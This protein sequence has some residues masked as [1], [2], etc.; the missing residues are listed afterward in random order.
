ML[1]LR[2]KRQVRKSKRIP[3]VPKFRNIKFLERQYSAMIMQYVSLFKKEFEDHVLSYLSQISLSAQSEGLT[4]RDSWDDTLEQLMTTFN[5]GLTKATNFNQLQNDL[6]I[7]ASNVNQNNSEQLSQVIRKMFNIDLLA[8]EPWLK[9]TMNSFV[10][11]GVSLITNISQKTQN[12]LTGL[13]QRDIKLGKRFETIKKEIM[14][15]NLKPGVFDKLSTRAELIARDQVGK[16]NGQ[17]SRMRQKDIGIEFYVWRTSGDERVRQSHAVLDGKYCSWN[18]D[19]VY[20]DT[21][22]DAIDGK[23]KKRNSIGAFIG[24]PGQDYQCR[25]YAEPVFDTIM[26]EE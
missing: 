2:I 21:L 13:I 24:Q 15:T 17:M 4:L 26:K 22:Q 1:N 6:R 18:D 9:S 11:E 7:I 23:W 14:G 16:L 12:D 3:R 8:H 20:A 10:K 5:I 25:C 19:T